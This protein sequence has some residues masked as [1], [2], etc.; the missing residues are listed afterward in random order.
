M[1][2]W[3][4]GV[5]AWKLQRLSLGSI[6][7]AKTALC[8]KTGYSQN[9]N[10]CCIAGCNSFSGL[11]RRVADFTSGLNILFSNRYMFQSYGHLQAVI[12]PKHVA[13]TE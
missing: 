5:C 13:V 3:R 10:L 4:L 12:R 6:L 7:K 8:L 1:L 9:F 2:L 11:V